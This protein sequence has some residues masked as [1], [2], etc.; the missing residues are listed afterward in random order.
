MPRENQRIQVCCS[1]FVSPLPHL[2]V[3]EVEVEAVGDTLHTSRLF[4]R[5]STTVTPLIC[6]VTTCSARLPAAVQCSNTDICW[7]DEELWRGCLKCEGFTHDWYI[8]IYYIIRLLTLNEFHP[9]V[10]NL[11]VEAPSRGH[12]FFN[13]CC[14][15]LWIYITTLKTEFTKCFDRKDQTGTCLRDDRWEWRNQ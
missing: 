6:C 15:N 9:L 1:L 4:H 10:P 13:L 8:I 12:E 2:M 3:V 7:P 14:F 5:A 11:R